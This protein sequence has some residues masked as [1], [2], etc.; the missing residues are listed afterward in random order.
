MGV[1]RPQDQEV[2]NSAL[3][4][5]PDAIEHSDMKRH[6]AFL[7]KLKDRLEGEIEVAVSSLPEKQALDHAE[8][9]IAKLE[10]GEVISMKAIKPRTLITSAEREAMLSWL[11]DYYKKRD[12]EPARIRQ[13][14]ESMIADGI[15][16]PGGARKQVFVV[17][18]LVT[19][20]KLFKGEHG[21]W[22]LT[23]HE[24]NG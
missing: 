18:G 16:I 12:N 15:T 13:L 17:T 9:L 22:R 8:K 3:Q 5:R 19:R 11:N 24:R 23:N 20:N 2:E 10:S 21:L 7:Y 6:L 4:S 14:R 1:L